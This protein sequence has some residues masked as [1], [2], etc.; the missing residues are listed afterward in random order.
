[1]NTAQAQNT[2]A[3]T[4]QKNPFLEEESQKED[5][6]DLSY[7]SPDEEISDSEESKALTIK[8][9]FLSLKKGYEETHKFPDPKY[10][11]NLKARGLNT[12][13]KFV[14][15]WNENHPDCQITVDSIIRWTYRE[16]D[17]PSD[18]NLHWE[19]YGEY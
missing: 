7:Y 5:P 12:R 8:H 2:S 19:Q 3:K 14:A 10:M 13:E 9:S 6:N 4:D 16:D 17:D 11:F 18:Y 1:M 15:W